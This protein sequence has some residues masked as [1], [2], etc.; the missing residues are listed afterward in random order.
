MFFPTFLCL[1][2]LNSQCKGNSN[3]KY[4]YSTIKKYIETADKAITDF[5]FRFF[6][7]CVISHLVMQ[8]HLPC[9]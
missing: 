9:S 4:S 8:H 6:Y 1:T 2:P 3:I 7:F 5:V